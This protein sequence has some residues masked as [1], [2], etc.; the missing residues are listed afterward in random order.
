MDEH[1]PTAP[2]PAPYFPVN[3]IDHI[4]GHFVGMVPLMFKKWFRQTPAPPKKKQQQKRKING[5]PKN[6]F[7]VIVQGKASCELALFAKD[8]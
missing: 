7:Y 4:G 2:Y 8:H 5:P 3:L 1:A 6:A